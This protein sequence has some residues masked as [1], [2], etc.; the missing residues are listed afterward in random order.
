MT[1][2][3]IVTTVLSVFAVCGIANA[4]ATAGS[5]TLGVSANVVG[6]LLMTFSTDTAGLAM[7]GTGT[8]AGTLPFGTVSMFSGSVPDKVTKTANGIASFTLSTPFG[9]RVDVANSPST[10]YFL[11]AAL[12]VAD[13]LN[14]W[15]VN[16]AVISAA[17]LQVA[18]GAAYGTVISYPLSLT[19]PATS[20]I[21]TINNTINFTA[22]AQ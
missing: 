21:Q 18:T 5:G 10:T 11:T 16:S 12:Q 7:T 22:T 2:K 19:V 9:V 13:A 8:A 20:G 4:Q 14:I 6:S 3:L 17:P 15:S 1:N